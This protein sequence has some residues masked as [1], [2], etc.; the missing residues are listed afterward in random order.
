MGV[1]VETM[2]VCV[3]V[4]LATSLITYQRLGR[5]V[6]ETNNNVFSHKTI[7]NE[8]ETKNLTT[9]LILIGFHN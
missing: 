8:I 1:Y 4:W 9:Q 3:S 5:C 7:E 2:C 6:K